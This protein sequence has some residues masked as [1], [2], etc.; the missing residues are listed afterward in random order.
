VIVHTNFD[1]FDGRI[2]LAVT[3]GTFDGVHAGHRA[4]LHRLRDLAQSVGGEAAVLTFYPHPRMVLYP[5]DHGL[6]LLNTPEEKSEL[7]SACGIRHLIVHPFSEAFSRLSA[8]DYVRNLLVNGLH[9]HTVV[10]GYDH[11]FGRNR[12]GDFNTLR[13][14]SEIF[15]FRVEEIPAKDIDAV[16]VSSTKIRQAL[17]AGDVDM[18]SRLLGYPYSLTGTVVSGDG[19][20]RH[21]GFPTANIRVE[22]PY[23]LIPAFGVYAVRVQR[24]A[25][26]FS[27]VLNIGVRPTVQES[28][29][30]Q[31]E[32]HLFDFDEMIYGEQLRIEFAGRIREER[33]F[34][35]VQELQTQIAADIQ[36]ARR[37]L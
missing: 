21:I 32:A 8:E 19:R 13:E 23:K 1:A 3:I 2:P 11:R 29:R 20:G 35:S 24:G 27:G 31:I 34:S 25:H 16:H 14:L 33:R 37:I 18:A 26:R 17:E 30:V 9:A 4:I 28:G 22:Y 12:E 10:V 5:D 36:A 7:L 15:G 6:R